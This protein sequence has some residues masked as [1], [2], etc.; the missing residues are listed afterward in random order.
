M[1]TTEIGRHAENIAVD[2]LMK[3]GWKILTQNYRYRR[4]EVDIIAQSQ[5]IIV[6]VEV[7]YRASDA[8]GNPEDAV[9]ERKQNQI[10]QGANHYV[11]TQ[12]ISSNIRFDIISI[13]QMMNEYQITHFE[14]AFY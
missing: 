9:D 6:F 14:D 10:I 5:D 2:F 13:Q 4:S 3:K 12:N 8:F 1:N 11:Y 7:K